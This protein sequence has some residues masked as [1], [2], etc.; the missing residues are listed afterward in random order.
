M[1]MLNHVKPCSFFFFFQKFL[2]SKLYNISIIKIIIQTRVVECSFMVVN[3][4]KVT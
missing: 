2:N 4:I 1:I 3:L